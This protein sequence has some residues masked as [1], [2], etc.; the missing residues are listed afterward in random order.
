M[1]TG[2]HRNWTHS[3]LLLL[4]AVGL[5]G[6]LLSGGATWVL[7]VRENRFID[8]SFCGDAEQR[9]G[10]ISREFSANL[11]IFDALTAFYDGSENVEPREFHKFVARFLREYPGILSVSMARRVTQAGRPK[12]EAEVRKQ[13]KVEHRIRVRGAEGQWIPAGPAD[14]YFPVEFLAPPNSRLLAPGLDLGANPAWREA[15]DEAARSGEPIAAAA[16]PAEAESGSPRTVLFVAPIYTKDAPTATPGERRTSLERIVAAEF[17]LS[18][19]LQS[20]LRG[21]EPVGMDVRLFQVTREGGRLLLAAKG[22]S[23]R[24]TPWDPAADPFGEQF[25]ELRHEVEYPIGGRKWLILC[26]PTD[27]YLIAH[28]GWLPLATLIAGVLVTGLLMLYVSTL[29]SHAVRVEQVVVERTHELKRLNRSLAQEVADR[30]RAEDVLQDSEALYSSLVENLPVQVLRK[31]LEGKF[32]FA[33]KSF[34]DL[35]GKRVEE[36]LGKTDFDFYPAE[37]A[38]KYRHDD[39]RVA[40]SGEIFEDTEQYKKSGETRYVHVMKSPVRDAAGNIVETQVVFWDVTAQKTAEEHREQA[41]A[42]AE[43]ANRAKSTF[44]ASMSHEIRTPLNAILGMTE[45]V[46]ETPL[47][48]E[49]R[50][51]LTVIGESGEA[52]FSLV[53]DI[54]DFSRIEAGKLDLDRSLFD[55]H[56]SLGD[57]L[58]SLAPRAH[59]KGLELACSIRPGVPELVIGDANRLRQV[60]VNLVGNA[61]KFTDQGEVLV[62]VEVEGSGTRDGGL[63]IRDSGPSSVTLHF[64]VADTGIGIPKDKQEAIFGAFVQG[65]TAMKRRVGG[66]GLGLAISSRLVE[67]SGGRIWVESQLGRGSTFHFTTRVGLPRA[68]NAGPPAARPSGVLGIRALVVDDNATSRGILGQDLRNWEME[69]TLAA[70]AAE[71]LERLR[72][73]QHAGTPYQLVLADAAMPQTDGFAL[74]RQIREEMDPAPATIMMLAS[75][76]RAGDVSRCEQLGVSAYVLKPIKESEL[77]DAVVLALGIGVLVEEGAEASAA[78]RPKPLRCLRILLAEDSLVNQ[79]LV[80]ALLERQGHTVIVANDGQEAVGAFRTQPVDLILMDIQMPQMDGLEATIAIRQAEKRKGTHV[81]IV[82]MTAHAMQGDRERCLEAGMDEYLAKPIRSQRLFETISAMVDSSDGAP[83][84]AGSPPLTPPTGGEGSVDWTSALQSV[85]GD[86]ALLKGI[87]AAFLEESPRLM[88]ELAQAVSGASPTQVVRPAHT[89][90]G[91]LTYLGAQRACESASQLEI[92]GR[93]GSLQQADEVFAALES[94]M[95]RVIGAL[96]DY[97]QLDRRVAG[98]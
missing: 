75:G 15:I 36:I 51:Y 52:L 6:L 24:K 45:L 20:A 38:E 71:A 47:S 74:L 56:D 80:K 14:A 4:A 72:Q 53:S 83:T 44:L 9:V 21:A 64:S 30:Q 91:S 31:N 10:A 81:P 18:G 96:Q 59:R 85:Q 65:E 42:A 8:A 60:I 86:F 63:G 87:I 77:F 27:E 70:S 58:K 17:D 13:Q 28:R 90:K 3:R 61:I 23:T 68:E 39:H 78:A 43:A 88:T 55:L 34:C 57:T 41:K 33:N 62:E 26:T 29:V 89:L 32:T 76:D 84:A 22:A 2:E 73:G 94:E 67:L 37:L 25:G 5:S 66:T 40:E 12:Y 95:A 16:I 50:E 92:M 7:Y 46:L 19:I 48:G 82:A 98:P 49:Q 93:E 1:L 35:L 97:L 54:L 69:P 11:A 79:K